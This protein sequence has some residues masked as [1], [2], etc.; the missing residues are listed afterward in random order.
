V[1]L[2]GSTEALLPRLQTRTELWQTIR[3]R[4]YEAL[5]STIS[6]SALPKLG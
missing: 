6:K 4:E 5:D 3:Y 2:K 1:A